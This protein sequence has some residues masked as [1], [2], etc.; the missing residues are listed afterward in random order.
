[1]SYALLDN[2]EELTKE[3]FFLSEE[4]KN[5]YYYMVQLIKF[6]MDEVEG[7]SQSAVIGT[8]KVYKTFH[9]GKLKYKR[10][11]KPMKPNYAQIFGTE[12]I[13][14]KTE[15]PM[16]IVE[17]IEEVKNERE[18]L[19]KMNDEEFKKRWEEAIIEEIKY[20]HDKEVDEKLEEIKD[21]QRKILGDDLKELNE[22][23]EK[24]G[25]KI[26]EME[27]RNNLEEFKKLNEKRNERVEIWRKIRQIKNG[28]IKELKEK[29]EVVSN[30]K[31]KVYEEKLKNMKFENDKL[32]G[33]S[34]F[35]IEDEREKLLEN[36]MILLL[37]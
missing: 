32:L 2:L 6:G 9:D 35:N 21:E 3:S 14:I 27:K 1:M 31:E 8:G 28:S 16:A 11:Y 22:K 23:Y 24:L 33:E 34:R 13:Q 15:T 25:R 5:R 7:N 30:E 17:L 4:I 20:K 18:E 12:S 37:N 19:K 26:K 10:P 36:M 29:L